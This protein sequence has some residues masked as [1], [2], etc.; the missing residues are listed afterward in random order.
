[1]MRTLEKKTQ[2]LVNRWKKHRGVQECVDSGDGE[3][4]DE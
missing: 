1:M 4:C 2:K 3:N